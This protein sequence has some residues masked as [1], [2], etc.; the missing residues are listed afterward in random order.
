LS[1]ILLVATDVNVLKQ[2]LDMALE[3]TQEAKA[4]VAAK[5]Y[6]DAVTAYADA[7]NLGRKSAIALQE[8]ND[9]NLQASS[10]SWLVEV[11]SQSSQLQLEHLQNLDGARSDAWAACVFSKYRQ[12]EPLECMRKVCRAGEDAI[13]EYQAIQQLLELVDKTSTNHDER[14]DELNSR[15]AEL[16]QQLDNRNP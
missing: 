16:K 13:G 6:Q 2:R 9:T 5:K 3:A 7:L 10:L 1:F 15:L 4:L 14:Q 8:C 12:V 11:C